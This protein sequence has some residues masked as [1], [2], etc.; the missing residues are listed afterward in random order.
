MKWPIVEEYWKGPIRTTEI[1]YLTRT[2][3]I[4][5]D[6]DICTACGQCI[7]ACTKDVLVKPTIPKG[8]KV[9][10][11]QRIPAMEHPLKCVFC[12]I[13]MALCPFKAI[14]MEYNDIKVK[15]ADLPLSKTG[16]L[17]E[18]QRVKIKKVELVNTE[19]KSAFWNKLMNR[20]S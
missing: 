19:F 12:G 15:I 7:K 14:S 11:I 17:P 16:M 9:P 18:I 5:L 6:T 1:D 8:T 13:C 10:K 20:I 4:K 2:N 3:K